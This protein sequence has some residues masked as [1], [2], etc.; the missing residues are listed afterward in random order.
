MSPNIEPISDRDFGIKNKFLCPLLILLAGTGMTLMSWR[1]WG[2]PIVD[3]GLQ[4][5]Y[6]WRISEGLVLYKD[7][8]HYHGPLSLYLNALLFKIFGPGIL[9]LDILNLFLIAVLTWLFFRLFKKIGNELS[10]T[11]VGLTFITVFAFA[12]YISVGNYNFVRPYVYEITHGIV[13]IFAVVYQLMKFLEDGIEKRVPLTGF[14]VGLVLLTK[15]EVF[16]AG[17]SALFLGWVFA[18][19][20]KGLSFKEQ[21]RGLSTFMIATTIPYLLFAAY[22]CFH[23]PFKE[24]VAAPLTHWNYLFHSSAVRSLEHY[25]AVM[26]T[27]AIGA[28]TETLLVSGFYY[29]LG[30][31]FLLAVNHGCVRLFQNQ[32][33]PAA[34]LTLL[35]AVPILFFYKEIPW[36]QLLRPLPLFMAGL[37]CFFLVAAIRKSRTKEIGEKTVLLLV[38]SVFS[39]GMV[40]KMIL[41]SHVFHYGFALV[42]P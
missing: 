11:A 2:D 19:Q 7:L 12:Q 17:F 27:N 33:V 14:L 32:R 25:Q 15:T 39:L 42:L 6:S 10:A 37:T 3:F 35:L 34:L 28:N 1:K 31:G 4:I 21:A 20:R 24:A 40:S 18:F 41:N 9:I 30:L 8:D 36:P 22:F 5:Y 23:L 13:L 16:V 26:G 29:L 38:L